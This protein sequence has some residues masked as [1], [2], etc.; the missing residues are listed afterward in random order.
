[1]TVNIINFCALDIHHLT[2]TQFLFSLLNFNLKIG[3]LYIAFF[4]LKK[5]LSMI[6]NL[7]SS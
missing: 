1:M 4:F 3:M 6:K 7:F 2:T 5:I